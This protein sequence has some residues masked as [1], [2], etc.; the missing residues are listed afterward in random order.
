MEVA[1]RLEQ[2]SCMSS[3]LSVPE[4]RLST[5]CKRHAFCLIKQIFCTLPG[6]NFLFNT[7]L[8]G[9]AKLSLPEV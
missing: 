2:D 9:E 7:I 6:Q 8:E 5:C 1:K 4:C 3:L